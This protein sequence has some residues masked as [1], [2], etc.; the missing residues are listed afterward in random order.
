MNLFWEMKLIWLSC[1]RWRVY[2]RKFLLLWY[3]KEFRLCTSRWKGISSPISLHTLFLFSSSSNVGSW[4][5]VVSSC[6]AYTQNIIWVH[7]GYIISLWRDELSLFGKGISMIGYCSA[8]PQSQISNTATKWFREQVP[9]E[10]VRIDANLKFSK[11]LW[12]V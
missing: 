7:N 2:I 3:S 8:Q 10:S 9:G 4:P 5:L 1:R 12:V 6:L 11:W